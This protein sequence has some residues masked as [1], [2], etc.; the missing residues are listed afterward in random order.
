MH[1]AIID[2]P[3]KETDGRRDPWIDVL[4]GIGIIL[5]I[6]GHVSL[7]N[8][9]NEWIYTFHMPLFFAL[10]G[11]LWSRSTRKTCLKEFV[12]KRIKTILWPYIFFR[13]LLITYWA[14]VESHFRQLDIGPI[15]FLIVLFVVEVAEFILLHERQSDSR[16][17]GIQVIVL[18]V[19]WFSLKKLLPES[20][21]SA[22]L[23]RCING[24]LFYSLGCLGGNTISKGKITVATSHRM[25]LL[26]L[27]FFGTCAAG[28]INPGA[29]MWSNSYGNYYV[30]YLMGSISGTLFLSL[31]CKWVIV[32]NRF[33]EFIGQNTITILATHEPIKRVVL[34]SIEYI[35]GKIGLNLSISILQTNIFCSIIVMVTVLA[36]DVV[37]VCTFRFIKGRMPAF[38]Q[39]EFL[40]FVR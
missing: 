22:W 32:K 9:L 28:V 33:L 40:A 39:K 2:I 21:A 8:G 20:W 29:S 35:G 1:N 3:V 17:N 37:V 25:V 36:I 30:V 18:A 5:V 16:Y 13:I 19:S 26:F 10:S 6:T 4:K 7:E 14:I 23:L 27:S 34:K 24:L 38:V 15:W 11:Y 31:L 12:L